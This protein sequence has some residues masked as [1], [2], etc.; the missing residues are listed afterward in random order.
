MNLTE[1]D[2]KRIRAWIGDKCGRMRCLCCGFNQWT[3]VQ[4]ATLPIGFDVHTTRFHYH[5]GVPQVSI[6]CNNCGHFVFFSSAKMGFQPDKPPA[7]EI[8]EESEPVETGED[9]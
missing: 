5:D 2:Q 8:R 4:F 6:A 3:V 1:D 7:H 9:S